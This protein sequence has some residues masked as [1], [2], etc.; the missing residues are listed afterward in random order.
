MAEV[1]AQGKIRYDGPKSLTANVIKLFQTGFGI[2][3]R[4]EMYEIRN[5]DVEIAPARLN[6]LPEYVE[7]GERI[8]NW[9]GKRGQGEHNI[10]NLDL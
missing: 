1:I 3:N 2:R 9:R 5:G 8:T 7:L 10:Y 6:G 4:E